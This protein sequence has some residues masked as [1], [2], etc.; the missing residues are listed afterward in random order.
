MLKNIPRIMFV[1]GP[2]GIGKDF[3]ID[4]LYRLL[5]LEKNL[6]VEV[7]RA[8]DYTLIE[9]PEEDRKYGGYNTPESVCH[10]IFNKHLDFLHTLKEYLSSPDLVDTLLINRSVMS[11]FNYNLHNKSP[12]LTK[13][14]LELYRQEFKDILGAY[15]SLYVQL[16]TPE[17]DRTDTEILLYR[18]ESRNDGK[19]VDKRW[20]NKLVSMYEVNK[21]CME[22]V[23]DRTYLTSS[24]KYENLLSIYS[25]R[26]LPLG[27]G[28][29]QY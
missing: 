12:E 19:P 18:I 8:T 26:P 25:R 22:R 24:D 15:K 7:L 10:Q 16:V 17:S 4:K 1:D 28:G 21:S 14:Y 2:T 23:M 11:F 5:T 6:R 20:I 3:F 27:R 29:C 9:A 13:Y